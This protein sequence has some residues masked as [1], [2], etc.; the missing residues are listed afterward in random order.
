MIA[1]HSCTD[2]STYSHGRQYDISSFVSTAVVHLMAT[3]IT[4]VSF[5]KSSKVG[6][7]PRDAL[8]VRGDPFVC[9][10]HPVRVD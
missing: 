9:S 4:D 10:P 3:D 1:G 2:Y 8:T 6:L 5:A 7:E